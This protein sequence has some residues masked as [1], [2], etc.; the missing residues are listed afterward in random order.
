MLVASSAS[1]RS[2]LA[3]K[4][5]GGGGRTSPPSVAPSAQYPNGA[6]VNSTGKMKFPLLWTITTDTLTRGG[7]LCYQMGTM[8]ERHNIGPLRN[9]DQVTR[10]GKHES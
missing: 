10:S 6:H 1:L 7:K 9:E 2:L 8:C 5:R 4:A 3:G